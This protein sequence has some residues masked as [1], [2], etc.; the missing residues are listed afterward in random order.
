M[1]TLLNSNS[2]LSDEGVA[3][4]VDALKLDRHD[5]LPAAIVRH[6]EDCKECKSAIVALHSLLIEEPYKGVHHPSFDN[7]RWNTYYRIAAM[8]LLGIGIAAAALML[9]RGSEPQG[10]SAERQTVSPGIQEEPEPPA[11]K[12][13]SHDNRL[14]ANFV[15]SPM[16]EGF[17]GEHR[18]SEGAE[19]LSPSLGASVSKRVAFVWDTRAAGPFLLTVLNNR[20]SEVYSTDVHGQS[21]VLTKDLIPGLY[22][23]KVETNDDVLLVGKFLI[24]RR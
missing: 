24:D 12:A 17:V 14:A 21:F 8:V 11:A 6:V 9:E 13:P 10:Q 4:Y 1:K 2:H 5:E 16:Y 23:W 15:P 22:Y 3:L 18:R 20:G 19:I 7:K